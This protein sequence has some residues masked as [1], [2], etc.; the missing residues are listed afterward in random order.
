MARTQQ[1]ALA[2]AVAAVPFVF[3][4]ACSTPSRETTRPT[5]ETEWC[6]W[7]EPGAGHPD[8]GRNLL[9][10]PF[11]PVIFQEAAKTQVK[12]NRPYIGFQNCRRCHNTG[13]QG[14]VE[15]PGGVK[16]PA[17]KEQWVL[18]REIPI[19]VEK[20]KHVQA[21]TVLLNKRS[22]AMGKLLGVEEI[23]RD[24]RCLACHTGFPLSQMPVE[25][26]G[27]VDR[28]LAKNLDINLGVSCEGCHGPS[29]EQRAD[30]RVVLKGWNDPHQK[31]LTMPY[32]KTNPWRFMAPREK[33]QE[34]GFFDVRSPSSKTKLCVSCHLGNVEQ[35][36]ILTHEMF[37]AGHPPLPGFEIEIFT[38]QM[39][40]HWE[41]FS[42]KSPEV[43]DR[44]LKY[45]K[46]TLYAGMSY[47]K[48]ALQRTRSLLTGALISSGEYLR[49]TGQLADEEVKSSV[50][51]PN[52]PEF[53]AF[54]C[55][56][57]HHD[58]ESPSW[59]QNRKTAG[60]VPGRPTLHDWPFTLAKIALQNLGSPN[61]EFDAKLA[62][63]RQ[64]MNTRPFGDPRTMAKACQ[65]AA[66]WLHEKALQMEKK[67]F[68][69]E[70]AIAILK[71]IA[72]VAS[73]ETVDYDSARQLVWA[74][75][76]IDSDLRSNYPNA[77]KVRA[78]L[79]PLVTY[80]EKDKEK[81]LL[82]LRVGKD[83]DKEMFL[84]NLRDGREAFTAVPGEDKE[85]LTVEV[86]LEKVFPFVVRYR[87]AEFQDK[88][89]A[90]AE[91]L[92]PMGR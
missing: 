47:K 22:K 64:A 37:A 13:G 76:V 27:L 57:C 30:N 31:P 24:Q 84:L 66:V 28:N 9:L 10:L 56:A 36:R 33:Q 80:K 73:M 4:Y 90:V 75:N 20:D 50:K 77:E 59:R 71:D 60:R 49:L 40:K 29:G 51:K 16:L 39:P 32:E 87:P 7:V 81:F 2:L 21:Y 79:E 6:R 54:D 72:A 61:G 18:Y 45:T 3:L 53:A 86:N 58:L 85:R 19:W 69:Q 83:K 15:L 1:I 44:F 74:F 38:Q 88:F 70:D 62:D 91:L 92:R 82:N 48:D 5:G 78:L 34:Y 55:Y 26:D 42:A 52:W 8:T 46:D 41:Y 11:A 68:S 43:Q 12:L 23:H 65:P 67:H 25:K 35:G 63:V 89:K 17:D 14:E